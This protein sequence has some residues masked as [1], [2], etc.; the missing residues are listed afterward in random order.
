MTTPMKTDS[1]ADDGI[2]AEVRTM[3]ILEG[4]DRLYAHL[5][6]SDTPTEERD[7]TRQKIVYT[8]RW[9]RQNLD[10]KAI[11]DLIRGTG[12]QYRADILDLLRCGM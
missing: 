11:A 9:L 1:L 4:L 7:Q 12:L 2:S 3:V 10:S 6:N 8:V 5:L